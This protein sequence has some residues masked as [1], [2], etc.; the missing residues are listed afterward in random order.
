MDMKKE[1]D[2]LDD[3]YAAYEDE[4]MVRYN[5]STIVKALR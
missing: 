1:M 5:V 4:G 2:Q 3:D